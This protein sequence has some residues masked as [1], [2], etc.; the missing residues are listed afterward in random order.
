MK[1]QVSDIVRVCDAVAR[2]DLSHKITIPVQGAFMVQVKDV[3]NGMVDK[4]IQFA[5]GV[6]RVSQ[7]SG[8]Q[9]I[10][11]GHACMDDVQGT[12]ADLTINLNVSFVFLHYLTLLNAI[13]ELFDISP[14]RKWRAI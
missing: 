8:T 1:A 6:A 10:F 5:K 7:E 4:L 3:I 9:C 2:G 13:P 12:W 14:C 11:G